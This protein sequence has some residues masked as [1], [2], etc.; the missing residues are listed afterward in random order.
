MRANLEGLEDG[1]AR[2]AGGASS[3]ITVPLQRLAGWVRVDRD[4]QPGVSI[5]EGAWQITR[6]QSAA[7]ARW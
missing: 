4:P 7:G 3:G 2:L 5:A 6:A 1:R